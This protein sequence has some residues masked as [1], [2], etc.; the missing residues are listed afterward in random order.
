LLFNLQ[1]FIESIQTINNSVQNYS[2]Q[3]FMLFDSYWR[4]WRQEDTIC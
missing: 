4:F 1:F 3:F 2:A